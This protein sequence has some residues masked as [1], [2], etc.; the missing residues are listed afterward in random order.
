MMSKLYMIF[1]TSMWPFE[2]SHKNK[3]EVFNE[4]MYIYMCYPFFEFTDFLL[5]YDMQY[6]VGFMLLG[7]L[8]VF[9][10]VNI[11]YISFIMKLNYEENKR[12]KNLKLLNE[13]L[14]KERQDFYDAFKL[15]HNNP[16]TFFEVDL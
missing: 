1:L 14:F 16:K 11:V 12:M 9:S 5:D 2:F 7:L 4:L 3:M 10:V 15:R 6:Y 8:G 13:G